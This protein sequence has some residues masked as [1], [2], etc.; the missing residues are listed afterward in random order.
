MSLNDAISQVFT[1]SNNSNENFSFQMEL[2]AYDG[3]CDYPGCMDSTALNFNPIA[4][5]D[6]GSCFMIED[7]V[8]VS[9][10]NIFGVHGMCDNTWNISDPMIIADA[11]CLSYGYDFSVYFDVNSSETGFHSQAPGIYLIIRMPLML[12]VFSKGG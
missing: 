1:N 6:D 5:I 7:G 9:E 4:T 10:N 3:T 12:K 2:I 8:V 11:V